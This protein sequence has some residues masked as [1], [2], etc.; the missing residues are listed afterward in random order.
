MLSDVLVSATKDYQVKYSSKAGDWPEELAFSEAALLA[1]EQNQ[2]DLLLDQVPDEVD[3]DVIKNVA[4]LIASLLNPAGKS[5]D[6][7]V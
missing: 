5:T 6:Y 3:T 7:F 1:K 4:I 2:L